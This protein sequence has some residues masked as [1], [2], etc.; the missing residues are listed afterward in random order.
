MMRDAGALF[1]CVAA[2]LVP[3]L[4]LAGILGGRD[5]LRVIRENS[6]VHFSRYFWQYLAVPWLLTVAVASVAAAIVGLS[7]YVLR[8]PP[9]RISKVNAAL[10]VLLWGAVEARTWLM[11]LA[12]ALGE[13]RVASRP[14]LRAIS[15]SALTL[16]TG[17]VASVTAA[18][19]ITTLQPGILKGRR[20]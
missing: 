15:L 12:E 18:S 1:D 20:L 6:Y 16:A 10:L 14:R 17:V 4:V 5:S 11:A 19:A 13:V 2:A 7:G 3:A 8:V 9:P